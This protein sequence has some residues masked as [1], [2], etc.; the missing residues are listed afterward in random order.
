LNITGGETFTISGGTN[1]TTTGSG[2]TLT[3]DTDADFNVSS[4]T[5]DNLTTTSGL[6]VAPGDTFTQD[7]YS[8]GNIRASGTVYA[9]AGKFGPNS[10]DIDGTLGTLVASNEITTSGL[11]VTNDILVSGNLTAPTPDT[12]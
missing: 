10:V 11:M 8:S 2:N 3:I 5:I 12:R 1:I 6:I 9:L 4:L 7:L